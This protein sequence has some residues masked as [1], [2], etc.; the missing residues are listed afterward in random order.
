MRHIC[1]NASPWCGACW[2]VLPESPQLLSIEKDLSWVLVAKR[3]LGR[4]VRAQ[5]T[6]SAHHL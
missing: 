5:R 1:F 4:P 6:S 3:F 2:Q